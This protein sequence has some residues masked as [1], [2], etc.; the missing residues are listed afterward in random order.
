MPLS[1]EHVGSKI[2]ARIK[3]YILTR[4]ELLFNLCYEIPCMYC[5]F[6]VLGILSIM[7]ITIMYEPSWESVSKN[8]ATWKNGQWAFQHLNFWQLFMTKKWWKLIQN[9]SNWHGIEFWLECFCVV[10]MGNLIF[11]EKVLE[12]YCLPSLSKPSKLR[13]LQTF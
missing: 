9:S 3:I 8:S 12:F 10:T 5:N 4:A 13:F 1:H 11:G 6:I 2:L 7:A